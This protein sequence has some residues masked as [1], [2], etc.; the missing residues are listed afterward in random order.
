MA[1]TTISPQQLCDLATSGTPVDLIDVRTPAEFQEVHVPFAQNV[2]LDQLDAA[3]IACGRNGSA[4]PL[5]VICRSGSRGKQAC[6]KFLAA[7]YPHV[8]N[9]EGGT[10]AWDQAGLP[11]VRGQKAMSLERQVRLAAGLLVL[12]GAAL[13]YFV[14]PYWIGLAAFVGAGLVYAAVTDTCGMGMV[15]ARMPWNQVCKAPARTSTPK[16]DSHSAT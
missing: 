5:Y 12:I 3:R 13:G 1:L 16:A 2:P 9:V 6:E 8:V 11:V 14:S 10:L 7:G 15:L 4:Q